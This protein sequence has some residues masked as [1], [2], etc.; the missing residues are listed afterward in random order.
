MMNIIAMFVGVDDI[1]VQIS[2]M[3]VVNE[4]NGK[5]T[6]RFDS[7]GFCYIFERA[8]SFVLKQS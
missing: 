2:V 1:Q 7:S 5:P 6:L 8:V 3:I 4:V